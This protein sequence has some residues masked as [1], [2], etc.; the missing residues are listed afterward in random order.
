MIAQF[1]RVQRSNFQL[2][3]QV[4]YGLNSKAIW[5]VYEA[6]HLTQNYDF[7]SFVSLQEL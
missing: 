7:E 1:L 2:I 3:L 6:A 5:I 4:T